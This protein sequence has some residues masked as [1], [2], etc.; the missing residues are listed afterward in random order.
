MDN[1]VIMRIYDYFNKYILIIE[2]LFYDFSMKGKV[3]FQIMIGIFK[4][5]ET[6]YVN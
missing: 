6:I 1:T 5:K 3:I 2:H 4:K